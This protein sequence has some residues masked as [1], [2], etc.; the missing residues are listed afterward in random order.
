MWVDCKLRHGVLVSVLMAW[1]SITADTEEPELCTWRGRPGSRC[2][3]AVSLNVTSVCMARRRINTDTN[4]VEPCT[5]GRIGAE[6]WVSC[7]VRRDVLVGVRG[8]ALNKRSALDVLCSSDV[9]IFPMLA[10][11]SITANTNVPEPCTCGDAGRWESRA[12]VTVPR[13]QGTARRNSEGVPQ[14]QKRVT[15]RPHPRVAI[16]VRDAGTMSLRQ[17]Q[18]SRIRRNGVAK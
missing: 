17:A 1:R 5:W 3:L 11:P 9:S 2:G 10:P 14:C 13:P 8:M 4:E 16:A 15:P 7:E 18:A 6:V 12:H